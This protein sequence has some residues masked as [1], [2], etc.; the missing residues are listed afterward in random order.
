MRPT[1]QKA[2]ASGRSPGARPR[3]ELDRVQKPGLVVG[4][5]QQDMGQRVQSRMMPRAPGSILVVILAVPGTPRHGGEDELMDHCPK[6]LVPCPAH[7]YAL[8]LEFSALIELRVGAGQGLNNLGSF[9]PVS[10]GTKPS[11]PTSAPGYGDPRL[12]LPEVHHPGSPKKFGEGLAQ[13]L[14]LRLHGLP[15]GHQRP[16]GPDWSPA[17]AGRGLQR[18]LWQAPPN[19]GPG[20]RVPGIAGLPQPGQNLA[21]RQAVEAARVLQIPPRGQK[22]QG[23]GVA[24]VGKSRQYL[25]IIAF[26]RSEAWIGQPGGLLGQRFVDAGQL[27]PFDPG[28]VRGPQ[29][30]QRVVPGP[31]QAAK[32]GHILA[33]G[34]RPRRLAAGAGHFRVDRIHPNAP[35]AQPIHHQPMG[36]SHDPIHGRPLLLSPR[37]QAPFPRVPRPAGVSHLSGPQN[38]SGQILH[39]YVMMPLV[40]VPSD[41]DCPANT[42]LSQT[43]P[44]PTGAWSHQHDRSMRGSR[45]HN[46]SLKDESSEGDRIARRQSFSG[47]SLSPPRFRTDDTVGRHPL[48]R[49]HLSQQVICH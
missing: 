18:A 33:V 4:N 8:E 27:A 10:L 32:N 6:M 14:L 46:G 20:L 22:G 47:N 30:P 44:G 13:G 28:F 36:R 48:A 19:P 21:H 37:E 24:D 43:F 49:P 39:H 11:L 45:G 31:A 7:V 5:P 26:Q 15:L 3:A 23:H 1:L 41:D 29:G 25:P 12:I 17:F 34:F 40:P 9:R 16:H 35:G 2:V 38:M 42:L